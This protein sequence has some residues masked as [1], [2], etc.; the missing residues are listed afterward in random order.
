MTF[1]LRALGLLLI[2]LL[3]IWLFGAWKAGLFVTDAQGLVSRVDEHSIEPFS[4]DKKFV[5]IRG[6]RV[7][8]IDRGSGEPIVLLPGCPFQSF[9]YSKVIPSLARHYRV[10]APDLLGLGDTMV[11]LDDDY[12]RAHQRPLVGGR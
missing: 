6:W 12:R 3:S 1:L 2:V 5:D 11:R 4:R 10:I 9:E 7:A 8:Y